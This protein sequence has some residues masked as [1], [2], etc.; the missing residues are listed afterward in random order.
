PYIAEP[1]IRALRA[2][3]PTVEINPGTSDVS[4]VVDV[5]LQERAVT[6]LEAVGGALAQ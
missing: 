4:Q 5:R 1:V 6:A 3:V 2:G